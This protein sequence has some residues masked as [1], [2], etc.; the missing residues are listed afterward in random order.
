[1][2]TTRTVVPPRELFALLEAAIDGIDG[3][4][5][6]AGYLRYWDTE[7]VEQGRRVI[8]DVRSGRA[9]LPDGRDR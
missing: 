6:E 2:S 5:S 8:A 1:M 9:V 4:E 3:Y 7:K